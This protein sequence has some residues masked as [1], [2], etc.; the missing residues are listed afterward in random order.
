MIRTKLVATIGPACDD[1]ASIGAM[2]DA[3]VN[4]FRL[5]FSHGTLEG[6]EASLKRVRDLAAERGTIVAVMG[7]LCGPKIRVGRI[8]GGRCELIPGQQVIFQRKPIEGSA[9]LLSSNY[10]ALV[11]DA[12][13]DHRLLIDDGNVLLRVTEKRANELICTCEVGGVVSDRK[14]INLPDS[15]VSA[16]AL[17]EKDRTNLEWAVRNQLDFVA[18]SFVRRPEDVAE[19]RQILD[20]HGSSIHVVAKI[21]KPEAIEH[22]EEI[23]RQSDVVLVA[24]G[25]LGVEMDVSRVPIIQKEIALHC[26]RTGT[27]V[28]IATQ[29]LQSMVGAPVPTR[30]E[31]SDVANAILD[32]ADAVMLSAETSVGRYPLE[33]VRMIRRVAEHTESFGT[34]YGD[35]LGTDQMTTLPVA[36]AVVRGA[37]LVAGELKACLVAVW[38]ES[39]ETPRLLSKLRIDQPIVALAPNERICRQMALLY[40]VVPI[41]RTQPGRM[42]KMLADL[43]TVL[44]DRRLASADDQIVI[45][46]D[47]RTDLPGETDAL[48][49]HPVGSSERLTRRSPAS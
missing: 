33:A 12:R 16:P 34:R 1:T 8:A 10:P 20:Q 5:N 36:T 31:V 7:D 13:I 15:Q 23:V 21:E 47:S 18:L 40:G 25:D 44:L 38:T 27:P 6:H 9:R 45:V 29:M 46:A 2:I 3:G 4:A 26:R 48:F 19:L 14:G 35:E 41:C 17:T 30:A 39:G 32:H 22:L 49:I 37:G 42:E 11:D 43:D 24:R 28:I